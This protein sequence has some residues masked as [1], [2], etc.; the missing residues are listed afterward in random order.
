MTYAL[1][2]GKRNA[3]LEK[4]VVEKAAALTT[5]SFWGRTR[6]LDSHFEQIAA[7]GSDRL[8]RSESV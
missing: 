2:K 7:A 3:A 4:Q 5:R 8:M 1:W 6:F